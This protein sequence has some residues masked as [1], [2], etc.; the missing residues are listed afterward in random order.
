MGHRSFLLLVLTASLVVAPLG[1]D[2]QRTGTTPR[3]G[4]LFPGSLSEPRTRSYVEA[5]R[6]GLRELGYLE[7]QNIRIEFRWAEEGYERLPVLAAE[8]ARLKVD[9]IVAATVPAI[10]AAKE[11]TKTIPIVMA[12]VVDP[13]T[14]GLVANLGRPE[15]NLTGLSMMAPDL[16]GKQIEMVKE[17]IPRVSRV[18]LL[19][20]P[21]NVGNAAQ[22]RAAEEAARVLGVRLQA[23]EA[24]GPREVDSAFL[25]MTKER[26]EALVVLVDSMLTSNGGRI[27]DLA[28]KHRL[29]AVYGVTHLAKAGGLMAY[30]VDVLHLWRRAATF[31]DRILK[32]AKPGELPI[33]QPTKFELV[34]SLKTAQALGLRIPPALLVRADQVI[35]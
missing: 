22:L 5:F 18:A 1:T 14:T 4:F 32:G 28:R 7:D 20:N 15:G 8:L 33:E 10:K 27:I 2:A 19:W 12:I 3:V 25:A 31:V 17:V 9:V 26:A 23:L 16:V 13:V 29:P 21:A 30:G 35:E 6:Q 34:I 11:A 24:R